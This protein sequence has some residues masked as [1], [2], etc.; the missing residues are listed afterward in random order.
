MDELAA[1]IF[2]DLGL[3]NLKPKSQAEIESE[4]VR[5]QRDPHARADVQPRQAPHDPARTSGA[6][7]RTGEP[8]FARHHATTTCASRPGS[9]TIAPRVERRRHRDAGRLRLDGRVREVHRAAA[10][11]SGWCASCARSTTQ[12]QI[13]FITHHTEAKEVDEEEFFNL[14]ESGGTK[15]SSAYQLALDIVERALPARRTGTS[16]RSTSPTATTGARSTTSAAWSWCNSCWSDRNVFG[17]GEIQEG[18][19]RSPSAR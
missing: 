6:T 13:V 2:E 5:V 16:I 19:R 10:S 9:A 15:V 12:V 14:G 18:G 7:P 11:T 4:D 17:Y 3:P 1:L 8:R